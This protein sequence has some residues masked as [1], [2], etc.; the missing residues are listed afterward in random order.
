MACAIRSTPALP[1]ACETLDGPIRARPRHRRPHGRPAARLRPRPCHR[2]HRLLGRRG[3]DRL[4]RRRVGLRQVRDCPDDHGPAA[5]RAVGH[6]GRGAARGRGRAP[7]HAL[8]PARPARHAHGHDLS[9]TDDG[10]QSGDDGRRP[11]RRGAGDPHLA[12]R[13]RS[14]PARAADHALRAPARARAPDR[15]LPPPDLGRP[16]PA[17]HDRRGA[18]ARSG[19]ADRR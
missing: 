2:G 6:G 17:H 14:A 9:G 19:L 10:A 7:G 3:R 8:A 11:D 5:A 1:S 16:A 4:R 18:G 15:R 12:V 13:G